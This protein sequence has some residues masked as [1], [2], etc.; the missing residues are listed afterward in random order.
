VST[1]VGAD[2]NSSYL[3]IGC[4]DDNIVRSTATIDVTEPIAGMRV[5]QK[6]LESYAREYHI[7]KQVWIEQ[8]WVN[9]LKYP[10]SGLMMT[11]TAT[12]LE[13]AALE[14]DFK[15]QYIHPSSWR[16]KVYG[17]ARPSKD[18]KEYARQFVLDNFNYVT[19]HK[20][21]HNICEAILL[22]YYGNLVS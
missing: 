3:Y 10:R 16:Q 1:N 17:N 20:N 13:I 18:M 4:I 11:R 7:L 14:I 6:L 19:K 5:I 21:E 9:G 2:Y 15:P 22:G 12:I 8:P